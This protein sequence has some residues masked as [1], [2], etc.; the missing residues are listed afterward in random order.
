MGWG[1]KEIE[2][3]GCGTGRATMCQRIIRPKIVGNWQLYYSEFG[4]N[5]QEAKD[6]C[7]DINARLVDGQALS[8]EVR[9]WDHCKV[10]M[11][12]FDKISFVGT[13]LYFKR[14]AN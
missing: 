6:A 13:W 12:P 10:L 14:H 11:L 9:F 2:D 7:S 1:G 3:A 5:Y 8:E 4:V